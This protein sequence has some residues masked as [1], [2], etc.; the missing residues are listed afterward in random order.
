[1]PMMANSAGSTRSSRRAWRSVE[2]TTFD[3]IIDAQAAA[4][5]RSTATR[6]TL[7]KACWCGPRPTR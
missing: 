1:V 6:T 3:P 5:R 4:A 2:D 7:T